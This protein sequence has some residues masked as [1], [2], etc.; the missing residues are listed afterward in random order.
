MAGRLQPV[1]AG[2]VTALVGFASSFTVV[3]AG[4]RAVGASDAQAASGLLVL[5]VAAGL[6][7]VWLGLRHRLPMA[8]AWS[9]PGAAL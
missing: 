7:A 4:L 9:T 1:L 3:L 6:C 2:V 5:C 8:I